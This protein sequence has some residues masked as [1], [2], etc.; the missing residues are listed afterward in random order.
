[1]VIKSGAGAIFGTDDEAIPQEDDGILILH[2]FLMRGQQEGVFRKLDDNIPWMVVTALIG[3][4]INSIEN[5]LHFSDSWSHL[6][7]IYADMLVR[8]LL[9]GRKE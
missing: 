4:T 3:F 8:S 2:R 5:K 7:E 1:V 6:V 9:P